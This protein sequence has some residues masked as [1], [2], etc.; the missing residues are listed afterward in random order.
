MKKAISFVVI[1]LIIVA[2]ISNMRYEQQTIIPVLKNVLEDKPFEDFLSQFQI[3]YWGRII[4][5]ESQGYYKF[6]E[7]L[8]RKGVHFFGY[9]LLAVTFYIF[10]KKLKWRFP[11]VLAFFT[12]TVIACLDEF[13]QSMIPGRSGLIEDVVIDASGAMTLLILTKIG[14]ALFKKS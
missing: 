8:F 14:H 6:L 5:V 9:G 13:R 3:P 11:T 7:F 2:V 4:S 12:V 10:Y 1:G